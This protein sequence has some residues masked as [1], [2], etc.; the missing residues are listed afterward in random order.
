MK[1][2]ELP[3]PALYPKGTFAHQEM[4]AGLNTSW[5]QLWQGM[6]PPHKKFWQIVKEGQIPQYYRTQL[7]LLT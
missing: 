4:G 3:D 2:E 5:C 1:V 6:Y 7:L